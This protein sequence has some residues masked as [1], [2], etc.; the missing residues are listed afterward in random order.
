MLILPCHSPLCAV[1]MDMKGAAPMKKLYEALLRYAKSPQGREQIKYLIFGVLTT[2]CNY[3][4]YYALTRWLLLGFELAN[5]LA[6]VI[7]VLFAFITNKLFV[8]ESKSWSARIALPEFG[9]FVAAR[10]IS[11]LMDMLL[12]IFMVRYL[13]IHDLL[14]KIPSNILV[15][16]FNY[17]ASKWLIFRNRK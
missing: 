3:V 11:L 9:G 6:W 17:I 16:V 15:I 1:N 13:H 4:A 10:G 7:S 14:A 2:L 12:L 8:F 5:A